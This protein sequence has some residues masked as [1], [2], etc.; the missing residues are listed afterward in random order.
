[1]PSYTCNST[2]R[3]TDNDHPLFFNRVSK[4]RI[5]NPFEKGVSQAVAQ[6]GNG[7]LP[8]TSVDDE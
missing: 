6:T 5:E 2:K 4:D 8:R 3:L 7:Q 1:M